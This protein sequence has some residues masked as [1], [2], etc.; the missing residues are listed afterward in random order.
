MYANG[1]GVVQDDV[2]AVKWYH[3][4]ADQ[5]HARAQNNLG[6]MYGTGRGVAQNYVSA[7]LWFNVA[8]SRGYQRAAGAR[9][10]TARRMTPDQIAEA[11]R[12]ARKWKPSLERPKTV[13]C[14]E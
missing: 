10:F 6:V 7:H 3:K 12:L 8:A 14:V 11:Q 2:E 9:D 13:G 4:A 1:R 5:G